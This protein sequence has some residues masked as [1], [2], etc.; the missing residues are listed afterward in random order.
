MDDKDPERPKKVDVV[1]DISFGQRVAEEERQD[2]A[3]YVVETE[4]WRRVWAGDVD[5][6]FA[7]KGGGKSAIY[8]MVVSRDS[9]LF[10]RGVFL[11]VAEN[12]T[13]PPRSRRFAS[14]HPRPI[15]S[16]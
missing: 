2:L 5:V 15:P 4:H 7:P 12:P 6:V 10:N 16:S 1:R 3:T 11:A 13:A 9:E 14:T 8:S